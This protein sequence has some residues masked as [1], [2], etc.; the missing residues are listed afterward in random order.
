MLK[1]LSIIVLLALSF[2]VNATEKDKQ[3]NQSQ[4][5]DASS[6]AISQSS[7]ISGSISGAVGLG[8][9]AYANGGNTGSVSTNVSVD[10]GNDR[11]IPV[12][13]AIAPSVATSVICPIVSP[14][15]HAAQFLVFG[16]SS[17]GSQSLNGICVA[18]HLGQTAVVERMACNKD[19][20][21][22]KA[23]PNCAAK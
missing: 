19:K 2:N 9:S 16:G 23:N 11:I 1:K 14:T 8:G 4:T 22:A 17:T 5:A 10:N 13:S 20:D 12:S 21:Y 15:S 7:A 18:Y 3:G 6:S